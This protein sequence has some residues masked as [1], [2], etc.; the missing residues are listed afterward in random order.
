MTFPVGLAVGSG[1]EDSVATG[2]GD[3]LGTGKAS[4]V[5][6]CLGTGTPLFQTSFPLL[7][8]HVYLIPL[9]IFEDPTGLQAVPLFIAP[10]AETGA[11]TI[12]DTKRADASLTCFIVLQPI[13][14]LRSI[15][16]GI[17]YPLTFLVN[18]LKHS[19]LTQIRT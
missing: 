12:T 11:K 1:E 14:R 15:A 17:S 9:L 2:D 6:L 13:H 18:S 8:T 3:S 10:K 7:L 4:E 19:R 5:G 16:N